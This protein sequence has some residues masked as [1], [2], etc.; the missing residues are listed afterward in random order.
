[1][2]TS[3]DIRT[4]AGQLVKLW[5][6]VFRREKAL[7]MIKSIR[8]SAGSSPSAC[9]ARPTTKVLDTQKCALGSTK[10]IPAPCSASKCRPPN[11]SASPSGDSSSG[12]QSKVHVWSRIIFF[13]SLDIPM[14]YATKSFILRFIKLVRQLALSQYGVMSI[15]KHI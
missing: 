6:E 10:L 8:K 2:H 4:V 3:R 14:L 1:M 9:T 13:W 11:Q 5:M 12:G 7:G 15:W